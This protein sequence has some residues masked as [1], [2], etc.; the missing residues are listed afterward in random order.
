MSLGLSNAKLGANPPQQRLGLTSRKYLVTTSVAE[1]AIFIPKPRKRVTFKMNLP[2]SGPTQVDKRRYEPIPLPGSNSGQNLNA[3][4]SLQRGQ[5]GENGL[6]AR[7]NQNAYQGSPGGYVK[8]EIDNTPSKRSDVIVTQEEGRQ[9]NNKQ[10][11]FTQQYDQY[12]RPRI[13]FSREPYDF[14]AT[15][16]V[17]VTNQ[18]AFQQNM[19]GVH[20]RYN[21]Y[22]ISGNGSTANVANGAKGSDAPEIPVFGNRS[23]DAK[24][25]EA[26]PPLGA[27][28]QGGGPE[29]PPVGFAGDKKQ[30]DI[31][32]FGN[33]SN[34]T[35][36]TYEA[37]D[38]SFFLGNGEMADV[39]VKSISAKE[40]FESQKVDV[41]PV[42]GAD[43]RDGNNEAPALGQGAG[44]SLDEV[45]KS[46]LNAGEIKTVDVTA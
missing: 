20:E 44:A 15:K 8:M 22:L 3:I 27:G 18:I 45:F 24:Q 40:V 4:N 23:G 11:N 13:G 21:E 36:S 2:G 12:G 39:G 26:M 37:P 14:A 16:F 46:S 28:S 31:P 43:S 30:T 33:S 34:G 29:Q 10:I 42:F 19:A 7:F 32:I 41:I 25:A 9:V 17:S 35:E 5:L 6:T 1:Q 38:T